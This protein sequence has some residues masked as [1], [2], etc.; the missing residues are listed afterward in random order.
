MR[1]RVCQTFPSKKSLYFLLVS[2]TC[3]LPEYCVCLAGSKSVACRWQMLL[4]L[5]AM[6]GSM[7]DI[8][9]PTPNMIDGLFG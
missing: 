3:L 8:I 2:R 4:L 1:G 9:L 7:G 5:F 6:L